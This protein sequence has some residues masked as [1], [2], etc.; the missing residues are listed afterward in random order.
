MATRPSISTAS[1]LTFLSLAATTLVAQGLTPI[2]VMS[3]RSVSQVL[4]AGV[5]GILVARTIPRGAKDG[6]GSARR[7]LFR[8][9][10]GQETVVLTAGSGFAVIGGL[11]TFVGRRKGLTHSE[12]LAKSLE[13]GKVTR[14]TTTPHGVRSYKWS[15]DFEYIA[16]TQID[17]TPVS[18]AAAIAAGFK[19]K[20]YDEDY[21]DIS[22]W[23][24]KRKNGEVSRLT[25]A[26]SVFDFEWMK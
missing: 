22:L 18:R 2:Q 8:L 16:F 3:L 7:H 21:R 25:A 26:S 19:Q 23:L 14:V 5:H 6:V 13:D 10:D 17:P 15:P 1:F 4:D 24:W 11:V 20:V 9:K 12:V